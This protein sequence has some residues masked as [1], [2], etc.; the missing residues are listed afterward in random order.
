MG[1]SF[2]ERKSLIEFM[3]TTQQSLFEILDCF[4]STPILLVG[5]IILDHYIWG[6]VNRISPEAPVVVVNVTKESKRPGGAGNVASN[7]AALGA[8]VILCGV[9][10]DDS[11]GRE[12]VSSLENQGIDVHG[13]LLDRTRT[14]TVK[15]RIIAH[16]QQIVRVDREET[17]PLLQTYGEGVAAALHSNFEKVKGIIVSDYGKGTVCKPIFDRIGAGYA[18]GILGYG[19]IPVLVDPKAPNFSLYSRVTVIKPNRSE[20]ED[21][22]GMA[23]PDRTSA[24]RAGEILL[25]KWKSEMV[26]ITLG[27]EGMVLVSGLQTQPVHHGKPDSENERS[28]EIET[29]A[30]EVYDVSGAG[31]TVS[32]VFTLVLAV[33]ASPR[34]AAVLAN[35]A[36]GIVV[37]EVGTVAVNREEL[38]SAIERD[39]GSSPLGGKLP[40]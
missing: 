37:G 19:K 33:K 2:Y 12:V 35:Y 22:S 21:A 39:E 14:T 25:S 34:Q 27:E 32:A 1:A 13:V 26:L 38:R 17:N 4:P 10:G 30:R 11:A 23:I 20:A 6:K 29:M 7:L 28:I 40:V 16:A 3:T 31:D 36:A 8:R 18:N 15:T 9:V 5:D 24:I